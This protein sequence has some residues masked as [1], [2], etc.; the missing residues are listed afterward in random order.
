MASSG[1]VLVIFVSVHVFFLFFSFSGV[2]FD[3]CLIVFFVIFHS[4]SIGSHV[5]FR[6]WLRTHFVVFL[7]FSLKRS[8]KLVI[9]VC[10]CVLDSICDFVFGDHFKRR[11]FSFLLNDSWSF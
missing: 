7:L 6:V 8:V 9:L 5:V 2:V 4:F 11:G 10:N 3:L 1:V